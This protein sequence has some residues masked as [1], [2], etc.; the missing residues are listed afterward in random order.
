VAPAVSWPTAFQMSIA[1]SG[2]AKAREMRGLTRGSMRSAS[3][4]GI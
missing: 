2:T 4:T 3:A 1:A